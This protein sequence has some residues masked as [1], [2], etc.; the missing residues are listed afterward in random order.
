MLPQQVDAGIRDALVERETAVDARFT[1]YR[2]ELDGVAVGDNEIAAI[3][4]TSDD[5][6]ER[7]AAWEASK[8]VGRA[9]ADDVRALAR[10]RNAAARSLGFRDHFALACA[11]SELDEDR[12]LA[13]LAEVDRLTRAPFTTWKAVLDDRL[14]TR[15]GVVTADLCPWHLDDPF[16]QDPPV[17]GTVDLDPLFADVDP[18]EAARRTFAELAL[19]PDPI[20][21]VS[22]LYARAGKSQHAFCI[23]VDRE[24]DVRVLAN[25]EPNERWADTMLHE[26]G[27]AVYD[28]ALDPALPWLL[29]EP[30]HACVT[31]GIAMLFGRLARDPEW[32]TGVAGVPAARVAALAPALHDARRASLLVFVRWVLVVTHFERRLYA[33]PDGDLDSVWWDLVE[34]FQLVRRPAGRDAP[35]WAAKIHLA[36]VPVY[37]Q[38]YLYGE[39]FASLVAATARERFGGLAGRPEVGR[40][41]RDAVFAP[42][43]VRRWD[44]LVLEA[45]GTE[46]GAVGL[47]ADLT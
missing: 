6:G 39:M 18:V 41:L 27:H 4:R 2:A 35:D 17:A 19:D 40:Y 5:S 44:A 31:E 43:A 36:V 14:A 32:L 16:F 46:F 47:A 26:M 20:L 30:A 7:R 11:V 25:V 13:T 12:L 45:T 38:N 9:V 34:R 10:L 28:R 3:L 29:R 37:Y 21:A 22:D 15:F 8:Q 23:H 24:G 33:D 42:G 1:A